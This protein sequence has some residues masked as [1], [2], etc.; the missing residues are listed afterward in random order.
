MVVLNAFEDIIA[1]LQEIDKLS[2]PGFKQSPLKVCYNSDNSTE[3]SYDGLGPPLPFATSKIFDAD[4]LTWKR[5]TAS[6]GDCKAVYEITLDVEDS[7]FTF[8]AGDTIG[9]IPQNDDSDIDFIVSHLNLASTVDLPV[10]ITV[11]S[12]TKGNKLPIHIPAKS[13]LR[14]VLK[15][16]VE[17]RSLLKKA[18]LLS[19]SKYT[20][21]DKERKILEYLCSKE[22]AT[23]YST[24][25]LNKSL[26]ILDIFSIF[27]TCKPPIEVLLGNLSRLLPRPYSIVNSGLKNNHVMKICF[28]VM[29]N[30]NRKGL[31]T[32]WLERLLLNEEITLENGLK[33]MSISKESQNKRKVSI[34]L[35]KNFSMFC[36]PESLEKPLILI[37]PGT[38]VSPFIGFLEERELLKES[39]QD[40]KFGDVYLY[41]GCRN[42]KLDFIY[43]EELKDFLAKGT[44]TKLFTAFSRVDSENK[45]I[46]DALI[47]SGKEVVQLIKEGAHVYI[48]GDLNTM[49]V[50]VKE[51]LVNCL[52]E[53]GDMTSEEAKTKISHMQKHH[54][55]VVDAWS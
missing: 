42:P 16:C 21:D 29:T 12:S 55:Y 6:N 44:L 32:G 24:H 53:Y 20:E 2:L 30:N 35:R 46:Q 22:G 23:A 1:K 40:V 9:I 17:L 31:T 36:L 52:V 5:L 10:S 25:V 33:N 14:H 8:K 13:T 19:L 28:S 18:F 51:I 38:G 39:N 54:Q 3:T 43:E 41:F 47:E 37:G 34:Y 26:C 50:E 45:Y 49:A 15:Y 27:K 48:S 11:D 7:K 4:I